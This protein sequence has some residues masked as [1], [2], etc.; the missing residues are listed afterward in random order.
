MK[1]CQLHWD[2][3][4]KSI[5]EYGLL[6]LVAKDGKKALENMENALKGIKKIKDFDPLMSMNWHWH[7]NAL[8]SGG[9]YLMGQN[10]TGEND[11]QYC[12]LCEYEKHNKNFKTKEAID[13]VSVQIA[14]WCRE[15]GLL[16]KVS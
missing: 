2:M 16:P 15:Q 12:P 10:E 14:A 13:H 5:E 11:G 4:R 6:P 8:E 7:N 9:L 1:M 3:C